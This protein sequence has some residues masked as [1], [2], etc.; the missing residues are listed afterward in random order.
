MLIEE[1]RAAGAGRIWSREGNVSLME[2]ELGRVQLIM[3]AIEICLKKSYSKK[4]R[5]EKKMVKKIWG[6]GEGSFETMC[7]MPLILVKTLVRSS[8]GKVS[9]RMDMTGR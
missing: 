2:K 7:Q 4:K 6:E 9:E 8:P 3:L 1:K 5:E